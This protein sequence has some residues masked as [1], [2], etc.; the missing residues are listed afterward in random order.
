MLPPLRLVF[1]T[2]DVLV[3]D[4]EPLDAPVRKLPPLLDVAE[5]FVIRVEPVPL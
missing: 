3:R 2:V 1:V 5:P 4:D